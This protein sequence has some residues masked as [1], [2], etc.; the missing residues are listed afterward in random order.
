L[1]LFAEQP[2]ESRS[3]GLLVVMNELFKNPSYKFWNHK[4]L[5]CYEKVE[6]IVE[7]GV[8]GCRGSIPPQIEEINN[9]GIIAES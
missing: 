5:H 3:R 9:P 7:S 8:K 2:K 1:Y 6:K 4:S